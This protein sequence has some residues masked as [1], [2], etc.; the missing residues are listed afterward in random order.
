MKVKWT[1][2]KSSCMSGFKIPVN[3]EIVMGKQLG[4]FFIAVFSVKYNV[5]R[6]LPCIY[7]YSALFQEIF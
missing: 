6:K 3:L 4:M 5:L 2:S 1:K 7:T